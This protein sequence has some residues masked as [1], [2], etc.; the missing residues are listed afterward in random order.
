[1]KIIGRMKYV[2]KRGIFRASPELAASL[3]IDFRLRA[4]SRAFMEQEIFGYLNRRFDG[5]PAQCLF[6]GLDR[7]NWHYNRLLSLDFH[8]ID[9]NPRNAVYGQSGKHVVGSATELSAY[10]AP[11]S[12]DVVIANGLIGFGLN[13]EEAFNQLMQQCRRVLTDD[14]LLVLGYNDRPD[15]L[16]FHLEQAEGFGMF[17]TIEP[18][19]AVMTGARHMVIDEFRHSYVFLRPRREPVSAMQ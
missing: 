14:G 10:Y 9:L 8:S 4:P 13:T 12:F 18:D 6:I 16:K 3:G 19:I 5:V 11:A 15:L 1:M 2:F 7:H 17:E